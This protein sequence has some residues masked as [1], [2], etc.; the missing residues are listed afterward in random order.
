MNGTVESN[1]EKLGVISLNTETLCMGKTS[2][3]YYQDV[4]LT[5]RGQFFFF[6][7]TEMPNIIHIFT[8]DPVDY[9]VI[10]L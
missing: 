6:L 9:A 1:V 2:L 8:Q 7:K 3:M 5:P 10:S 4:C